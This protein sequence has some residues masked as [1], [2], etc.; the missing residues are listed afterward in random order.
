MEYLQ[1]VIKAFLILTIFVL[2]VIA[3]GMWL[4]IGIVWF[5]HT[6]MGEW[7]RQGIVKFLTDGG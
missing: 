1:S 4:F 3:W 5:F 2:A 7:V 6:E